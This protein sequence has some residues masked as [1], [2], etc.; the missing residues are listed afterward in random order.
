[1]VE[2]LYFC[3]YSKKIGGVQV[4][5]SRCAR[6]LSEH[7]SMNLYYLDIEDS[8][9]QSQLTGTK[10]KFIASSPDIKTSIKQNSYV[11]I[12]LSYCDAINRMFEYD[13]SVRYMLWSLQPLNLVEKVLIKAKYNL[14]L[15]ST[16]RLFG[17]VIKK[18]VQ[19]GTI[20]FM[21]YNNYYSIHKVFDVE[22]DNVNYIPVPIDDK[23]IANNKEIHFSRLSDE[24]LSFMWLSRIDDDKKYTLMTIMNEIEDVNKQFP[25]KL[26]IVGDGTALDEVQ[27][28]S[29]IFHYPIIFT[30][31]L[32]GKDLEDMIDEAVDVGV[33]MGTSGLEIAK[34]GKPVIMKT[35]LSRT[36]KACMIKDYIFL[37]QEYGFSLGSPDFHFDGQGRFSEK[38]RELISKYSVFAKL[39][40]EYVASYHSLSSTAN[41][42][43]DVLSSFQCDNRVQHSNLESLALLIKRTRK[44]TMRNHN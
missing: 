2:N 38:V 43:L 26:I 37:H 23:S 35:M 32:Y 1:M 9:T 31:C 21:D 16:K 29:D 42:L 36:Y 28:F 39:D 24:V 3:Y 18:L 27:R 17:S 19:E 11:I 15:P 13:N 12:P 7:S 44:R 5:F 6:Y 34:R 25:C 4:L 41:R 10:V 40:Y 33:G 30:G 14:L 20:Q 22:L 8:F